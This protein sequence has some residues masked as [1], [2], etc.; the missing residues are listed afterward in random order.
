MAVPKI[1]YIDMDDTSVNFAKGFREALIKNPAMPFPQSQ[2][3]FFLNLEVMD[4]FINFWNTLSKYPEIY[5]LRFLTAPS[6]RNPLSYMEKRLWVENHGFPPESLII[7]AE[8]NLLK[9][10]YLIDDNDGG[11]GQEAFEGMLIHFGFAP[12]ETWDKITKY[13]VRYIVK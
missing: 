2:V 5:T 9:G 13:F 11:K 12:F 8:K 6:V 1:I 4:G 3:G 10:Q 7:C